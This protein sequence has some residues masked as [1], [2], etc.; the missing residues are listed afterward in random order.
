MVFNKIDAYKYVEKDPF[1]LTPSTKENISLNEL[2]HSW[3]AKGNMPCVFI[4]A[5]NKENISELRAALSG[6]IKQYHFIRYPH[7]LDAPKFD[8]SDVEEDE[9]T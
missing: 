1:D 9:S 8:G 7:Y 4:S 3:M 6:L 5:T 2:K